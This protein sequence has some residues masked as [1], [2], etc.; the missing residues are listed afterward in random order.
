[1]NENSGT[2]QDNDYSKVFALMFTTDHKYVNFNGNDSSKTKFKLKLKVNNTNI[3]FIIHSASS[4]NVYDKKSF[5]KLDPDNK[6][7]LKRSKQTNIS[8]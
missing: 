4:I 1:M 5:R 6:I 7:K 3:N 8:L 2:S